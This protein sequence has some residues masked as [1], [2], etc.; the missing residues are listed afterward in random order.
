[1]VSHGPFIFPLKLISPFGNGAPLHFFNEK[2]LFTATLPRGEVRKRASIG[3]S[4]W[5]DHTNSPAS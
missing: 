4:G 1:M 5:R 3:T 2:P